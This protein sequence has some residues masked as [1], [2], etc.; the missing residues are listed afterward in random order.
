MSQEICLKRK[1]LQEA[2]KAKESQRS[3]KN[4][5]SFNLAKMSITNAH[6]ANQAE[7]FQKKTDYISNGVQTMVLPVKWFC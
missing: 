7:Y 2:V 6:V 3:F 1:E 5:N 4:L